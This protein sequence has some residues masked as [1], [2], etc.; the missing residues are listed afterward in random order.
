M[1]SPLLKVIILTFYF[2]KE[3][4]NTK[5]HMKVECAKKEIFLF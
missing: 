1:I 4:R 3:K 5:N 2:Y